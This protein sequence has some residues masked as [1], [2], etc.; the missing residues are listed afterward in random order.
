MISNTTMETWLVWYFKK[1]IYSCGWLDGMLVIYSFMN[2][3][4]SRVLVEKDHLENSRENWADR[5]GCTCHLLIGS[6]R[7]NQS[8]CTSNSGGFFIELRGSISDCAENNFI[9]LYFY[10][11]IHPGSWCV[12][13]IVFQS[14]FAL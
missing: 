14:V 8:F 10:F 6:A 9:T 4:R 1:N 11:R 5:Q 7:L 13:P 3:S 2:I 12:E